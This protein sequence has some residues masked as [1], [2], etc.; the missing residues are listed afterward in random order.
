MPSLSARLA[1]TRSRKLSWSASVLQR[2]PNSAIRTGLRFV[3]EYSLEGTIDDRTLLLYSR[4]VPYFTLIPP[5][6]TPDC[7]KKIP[8]NLTHK[9]NHQRE[10]LIIRCHCR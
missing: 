3:D 7:L 6:F 1:P 5:K 2:A 10:T 4:L 9:V 8:F